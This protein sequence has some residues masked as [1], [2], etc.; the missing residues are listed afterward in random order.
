MRLWISFDRTPCLLK[1][2]AK[3]HFIVEAV[4]RPSKAK[5]AKIATRI[6][7]G[8]TTTT[9]D[10]NLIRFQFDFSN[11]VSNQIRLLSFER[12]LVHLYI[13]FGFCKHQAQVKNAPHLTAKVYLTFLVIGNISVY[14]WFLFAPK[15]KLTITK[16][17]EFLCNTFTV[18]L[19][20][21]DTFYQ[22]IDIENN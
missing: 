4:D 10:V 3:R 18:Q 1:K 7:V 15:F 17:L 22:E 19:F 12:L 5:E 16:F 8:R 20:P 9:S 11:F 14:F 6:F 2:P 13:V 21:I